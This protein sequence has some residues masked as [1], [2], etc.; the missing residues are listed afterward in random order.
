MG[1]GG[2]I[3]YPLCFCNQDSFREAVLTADMPGR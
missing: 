3:E 2:E 1:A